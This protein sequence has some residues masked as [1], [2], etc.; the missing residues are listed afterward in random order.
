MLK[1][2]ILY[3]TS[4][5]ANYHDKK[6]INKL[7]FLNFNPK[8][9]IDVGAHIGEMTQIF[10]KNFQNVNKIYC[11]EPQKEIFSSLK[12]SL[13]KIERLFVLTRLALIKVP[14]HSLIFLFTVDLLR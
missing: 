6:I 14:T 13:I 4:I 8:I 12:K 7:I 5:L 9:I 1:N 3:F 10:L 11:F 2:I